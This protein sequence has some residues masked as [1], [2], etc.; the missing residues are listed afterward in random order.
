VR[1]RFFGATDKTFGISD[2]GMGVGEI[3]IQRQRVFVPQ[4]LM[5]ARMVWDLG[6]G[7]GQLRFCRREEGRGIGDRQESARPQIRERRSD[8]RVDVAGIGGE[9]AIKKAALGR[10]CQG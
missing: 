5:R 6:Q 7:L 1:L 3:S 10:Y 8:E 4:H 2:R 9:R